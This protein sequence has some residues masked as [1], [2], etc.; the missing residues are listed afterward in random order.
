MK[1]E[2]KIIF[3]T[4]ATKGIGLE[5]AKQLLAKNNTVII[6]A[7]NQ[8]EL[9]L[10]SNE[11]ENINTL[12]FDVLKNENLSSI[13]RIIE[14]EYGRLDVL[15]NNAAILNAGNF[16]EIDYSFEKIETEILT[17]IASPIKITKVLLPLFSKQKQ[18][19]IINI[20]SGVAYMPMPYL[21]VYSA[22]KAALQSFTYSLRASLK[23]TNI[24]VFEVLPPLVATQMTENMKGKAKDMKKITPY[25]CAKQ[26]INGIEKE[27]HTIHIG[28]SKSLYWGRRIF[29]KLVQ[30]QLNKM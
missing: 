15:I 5:L 10:I 17:N 14:Q 22:T 6:G 1:L 21:P 25:D 23:N 19:A 29:P 20:T 16:N 8:K 7:R 18:S 2:N 3:I 27:N 26:I 4:G 24:K 30:N 11:F 13:S 9:D 28:S 12:Y